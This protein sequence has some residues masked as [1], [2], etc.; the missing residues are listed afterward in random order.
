MPNKNIQHW[1]PPYSQSLGLELVSV[2]EE[3]VV[4]KLLVREDMGN[5]NGVM[6][7]GAIMGAA[8][9]IGGVAAAVNLDKDA[10][11]TTLESK[12]NFIRSVRIGDEITLTCIPLHRGRKTMIWQTTITRPDG[13]TAAIVTQTQLTLDWKG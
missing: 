9:S 8:D 7:G 12:T 2:S 11:T 13:R 4:A 5:R 6:H 3:E 1:L 10:S